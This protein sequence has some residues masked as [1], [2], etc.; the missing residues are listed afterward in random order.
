[1]K[2][3]NK[4]TLIIS[5]YA[6]PS[7]GGAQIMTYNLFR[8]FQPD[9]YSILTS[10]Y[11]INSFAAQNGRWL[12]GKYFFYDNPKAGKESYNKQDGGSAGK[13]S[14]FQSLKLAAKR[15]GFL[16]TVLSI[17]AV[18]GQIMMIV[19][20]GPRAVKQNGSQAILV[21]S[22][23]GPAMIGG[24][25]VHKITKKPLVVFMFDLYKGNYL[26]FFGGFLSVIFEP[27]IFK[28]AS[29]IIVNNDGTKDFYEK[30]YGGKISHKI[31]I[32]Y[33]ATFPDSYK[34]A[35]EPAKTKTS[36]NI[37]F[38]GQIYWPQLGSI[39]N[40]IKAIREIDKPDITLEIYSPNPKDYLKK[41]GISEDS[42]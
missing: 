18:V 4:K 39:K 40:L 7:I 36:F 35:A 17:P 33:N 9:S 16:K 11:N 28:S 31:N 19:R 34:P 13:R 22:D 38:T 41:I 26:P 23:Y 3:L 12:S 8:D 5:S 20:S 2:T 15:L 10:F 37:V 24:Y 25:I 27:L 21:L 6:P 30:E 14:L 32:V 29:R 42:K 1:M